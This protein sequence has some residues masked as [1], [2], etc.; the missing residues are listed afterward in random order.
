MDVETYVR[1]LK[2]ELVGKAH[3]DTTF[4]VRQK[5]KEKPHSKNEKH[6]IVNLTKNDITPPTNLNTSSTIKKASLVGKKNKKRKI[7]KE[8]LRTILRWLPTVC[9]AIY[10]DQTRVEYSR[11]GNKRLAVLVKY[12]RENTRFSITIAYL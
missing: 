3:S 8:V 1:L 10:I 4:Y 2:G 5:K 11:L 6:S 9:N 7:D 12:W